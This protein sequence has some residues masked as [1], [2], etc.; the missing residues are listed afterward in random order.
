MK[1]KKTFKNWAE[2]SDW[3]TSNPTANRVSPSI[4]AETLEEYNQKNHAIEFPCEMEFEMD[5]NEI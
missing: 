4:E 2:V 3:W 1:I 5:D